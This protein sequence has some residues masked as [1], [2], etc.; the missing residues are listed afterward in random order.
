[1]STY[2]DTG[3]LVSLYTPDSNSI[4]AAAYLRKAGG[5]FAV[6][7]F[8]ELELTN[9]IQLRVFRGEIT[10]PQA[11]A[12]RA[13]LE[14]DL[15]SGVF[16]LMPTP[17]AV[18]E[19]AQQLARKHTAALGVRTLDIL[20]VASALELGATAIYTFDRRQAALARIAGLRAPVRIL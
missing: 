3:F 15:V 6:T 5:P 17:P 2:L 16:S 13:S 4:K 10:V 7:L 1:L 11:K 18:Y 20:H 12:A 9:A 8:G 14:A 19:K